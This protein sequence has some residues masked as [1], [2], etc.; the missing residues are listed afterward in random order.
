MKNRRPLSPS[1][2]VCLLPKLITTQRFAI[3][4]IAKSL[5]KSLLND[6]QAPAAATVLTTSTGVA[7]TASSLE[8]LNERIGLGK[9]ALSLL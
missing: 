2:S 8:T 5:L 9:V 3:Y 4:P 1:G 6:L 7:Y